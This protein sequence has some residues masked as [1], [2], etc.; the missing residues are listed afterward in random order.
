MLLSAEM[1]ECVSGYAS[2]ALGRLGDGYEATT[3]KGKN[4][5][6]ASVVA[7]T[8]EARKEN[9]KNNTILKAIR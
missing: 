3:Y 5:V 8:Y 6:N 1:E 7:T 2:K 9:S 4:R